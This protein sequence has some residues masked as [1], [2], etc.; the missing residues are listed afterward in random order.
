MKQVINN[1]HFTSAPKP[2]FAE[3]NMALESLNIIPIQVLILGKY[4]TYH[5]LIDT[6]SSITSIKQ[7]LIPAILIHGMPKRN[8]IFGNGQDVALTHCFIGMC[9]LDKLAIRMR[10][11]CMPVDYNY[12]IVLGQDFMD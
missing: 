8:V 6:G 2:K 5:A 11:I 1:L 4:F 10:L 12:D 9:L 7:N 3:Q